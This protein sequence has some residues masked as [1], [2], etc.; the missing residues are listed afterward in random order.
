M[1]KVN[2]SMLRDTHLSIDD[3]QILHIDYWGGRLEK[4]TKAVDLKGWYESHYELLEQNMLVHFSDMLGFPSEMKKG[5]FIEGI[6]KGGE[7][8]DAKAN[9]NRTGG[10]YETKFYWNEYEPGVFELE[11]EWKA[12]APL[13]DRKI[14]N[15]GY[16]WVEYKLD[17]V[18]RRMFKKEVL[19]GNKKKILYEGT[20]EFR[21]RMS[22]K[23]NYVPQVLENIPFVKNSAG[24]KSSIINFLFLKKAERDLDIVEGEIMG[25]IGGHIKEWFT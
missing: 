5:H 8:P 22:Y 19:V 20:Y 18:C 13:S 9:E 15:T 2:N 11:L 16:G 17:V 6:A 12:R 14:G 3:K 7:M 1:S 24:L 23:N 25:L 21:N 10:Q 4:F